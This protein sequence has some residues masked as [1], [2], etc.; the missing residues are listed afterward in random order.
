MSAQI[1]PAERTECE[2]NP[3][4]GLMQKW[5][6]FRGSGA[7][8]LV[9]PTMTFWGGPDVRLMHKCASRCQRIRATNESPGGTDPHA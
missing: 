5:I 7:L 3:E 9:E 6:A 2:P 4:H 1:E 8:D